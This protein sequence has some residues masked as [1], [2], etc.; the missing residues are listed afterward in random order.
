M[1]RCPVCE[2]TFVVCLFT[3]GISTSKLSLL[4]KL[5]EK[6]SYRGFHFSVFVE[7]DHELKK[8]VCMAAYGQ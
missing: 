7:C 3:G 2:K 8:H 4:F 1:E 6:L 5:F